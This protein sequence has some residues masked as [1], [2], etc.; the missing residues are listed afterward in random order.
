L[1]ILLLTTDN[2]VP[3]ALSPLT[4]ENNDVKIAICVLSPVRVDLD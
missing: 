4:P 2:P 3:N 1:A